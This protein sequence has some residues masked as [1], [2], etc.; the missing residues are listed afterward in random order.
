MSD[1]EK[2]LRSLKALDFPEAPLDS[3]GLDPRFN[4][5]LRERAA[6]SRTRPASDGAHWVY[7]AIA[8]LDPAGLG[9]L[10]RTD[11]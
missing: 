5:G 3:L 8:K 2:R 11:H 1:A 7:R 10:A 9:V 4:P 6:L